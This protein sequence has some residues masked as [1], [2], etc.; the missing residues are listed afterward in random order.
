MLDWP[1]WVGGAWPTLRRKPKSLPWRFWAAG[2]G[3]GTGAGVAPCHS[4][5]SPHGGLAFSERS[6]SAAQSPI[7][8]RFCSGKGAYKRCIFHWLAGQ[9]SEQDRGPCGG[10]GGTHRQPARFR[11]AWSGAPRRRVVISRLAAPNSPLAAQASARSGAA[12]TDRERTSDHFE[13]RLA[14]RLCWPRGCR[15]NLA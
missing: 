13:N 5:R 14:A 1:R 12:P 10:A 9:L 6:P 11:P 3:A 2:R 15:P 8:L 7:D 4:W